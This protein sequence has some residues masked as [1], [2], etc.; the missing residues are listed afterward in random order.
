MDHLKEKF[1]E[2][3]FA[4]FTKMRAML[5][6][7]GDKKVDEV[8]ISQIFGGARGVKTMVWDT[9]QLDSVEGIRFRGHSIP[10]LRIIT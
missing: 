2:K 7:H 5:K 9:S 3:A 1:K 6:E 4:Q 8:K 10:E